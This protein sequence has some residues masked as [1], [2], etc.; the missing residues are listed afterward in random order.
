MAN[1]V[2]M[3]RVYLSEGDQGNYGGWVWIG[4]TDADQ[5][6]AEYN[7]SAANIRHKPT[8][9]QSAYEMQV[10]DPDGNVLRFGSEPKEDQPFGPWMDMQGRLWNLIDGR[11][12]LTR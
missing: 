2:L 9:F 12:H 1:N 11:W 4:V 8:N 6:F 5:L 3:V 10:L 7:A